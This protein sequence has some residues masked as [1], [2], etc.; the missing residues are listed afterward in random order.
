MVLQGKS[1]GRVGTAGQFFSHHLMVTHRLVPIPTRWSLLQRVACFG[2]LVV[3][4]NA[5]VVS[6]SLGVQSS[7]GPVARVR[8][9]EGMRTLI[10]CAWLV[11]AGW[12]C[13][14]E[15]DVRA[16]LP[17]FDNSQA[18]PLDVVMQTDQITQVTIP[19]VDFLFVVDNSCS[20]EEEQKALGLNFPAFVSWF[21]KS[22]LDYHV[23]VT[24][25]DMRDPTHGGRLRVGAKERWIEPA[26]AEPEAAF[27][28]MVQ[29]G[30]NGD[31]AE[32][33]RAAAF[34]AI[35]LLAKTENKGFIRSD[36]G[37]HLAVVS[38]ED[39]LSGNSPVSRQEFVDYL[40]SVRPSPRMVSFS[41]IVGPLT[42][43]PDIG[44]PGTEYLSV[45]NQVGG[46][47][48]PICTDDWTQVLDELG[49]LA[50]GLSREYFLSRLP[51]A[52]TIE[53]T[54]LDGDAVLPFA[55][56]VDWVYVEARNSIEFLDFVPD[57]LSVVQIT[58]D[59]RV[60]TP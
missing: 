49:F 25:T 5:C 46:V 39:D 59:V 28:Q 47:F 14:S 54:V 1:C 11:L 15:T 53:V 26:T 57:P 13:R 60:V 58:Y 22:G 19:S 48:W 8:A 12:G 9:G 29:M 45:T 37:L 52:G 56:G 18:R 55:E 33:G 21:I 43:C 36:A 3:V 10:G 42:G 2:P 16:R 6:R 31:P 7:P 32:R 44:E 4:L 41:S 20:M 23:G 50:A 24:S 51:V 40:L 34:T 30:T 38:D 27:A 35:E 17:S